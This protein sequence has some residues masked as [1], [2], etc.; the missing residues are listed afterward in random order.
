VSIKISEQTEA[1]RRGYAYAIEAAAKL[2]E[3]GAGMADL[4]DDELLETQARYI[5]DLVIEQGES[6]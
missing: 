4:I 6:R 1:W 3:S 5:R 2:I